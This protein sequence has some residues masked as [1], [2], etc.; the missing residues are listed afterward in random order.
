MKSKQLFLVAIALLC[1]LV[2][3]IGIIQAM[4][5]KTA[6]E[7]KMPMAP[8]LVASAHLDIKTELTDENVKLENWPVKLIPEGSAATLEE[9]KGKLINAR[10]RKGQPIVLADAFNREDF[11]GVKIPPGHKVINLKVPPEDVMIGL[12]N[13]GDRVD[14]IGVFDK[15]DRSGDRR[16]ETRTFLKG[17]RIFNIG[18]STTAQEKQAKAGGS[19]GIVGVL[20]TQ[21]QAET[22]VWAKKNGEIRLALIGDAEEESDP[23]DDFNFFEDDSMELDSIASSV[24]EEPV[25]MAKHQTRVYQG[26]DDVTTVF[27]D[28]DNN[29]VNMTQEGAAPQV[30]ARNRSNPTDSVNYEESNDFPEVAEEMEEDQ[31][32][33]E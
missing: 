32:R 15:R 1:G 12:M 9:V 13:P 21:K 19:S 31:Y 33:G 11:P 28:E 5:N 20:V 22:I 6:P 8:V 17:I 30:R 4:G 18:S 29:V 10:L 16:S 25:P 3:A 23:N 26:G 7:P 14:I 2:S 27:F 24:K